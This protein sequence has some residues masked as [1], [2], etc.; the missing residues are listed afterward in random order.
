TKAYWL[1]KIIASNLLTRIGPPIT[2][3]ALNVG[4]PIKGIIRTTIFNHFCGG[5]TIDGCVPAIERLTNQQ[6]GTILDYAV[7]GEDAEEVFEDTC[8]DILSTIAYA[9]TNPNISFSVFKPTG[10]GRFEL[11]E[12]INAR[13][14]LTAAEKSEYQ[15]IGHRVERI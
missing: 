2:N 15:R 13:E 1:F 14:Q 7:A 11:F 3:F 10:L 5:E 6:V 4:I 9:Q 8:N 12:K